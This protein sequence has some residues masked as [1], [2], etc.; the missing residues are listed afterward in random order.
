MRV[1]I[2]PCPEAAGGARLDLAERDHGSVSLYS[3]KGHDF[4]ERFPLA[5][6]AIRKLPV[7]SCLIDGEAIICDANGLAVFDLL[8]R[9]QPRSSVTGPARS[10]GVFHSCGRSTSPADTGKSRS[11]VIRYVASG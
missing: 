7:R 5:A 1:R 2:S 10:Q 3:R 9:W 11:I 6:A 8:R 4:A